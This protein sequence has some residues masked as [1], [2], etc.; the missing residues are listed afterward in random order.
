METNDLEKSIK[1][2]ESHEAKMLDLYQSP[3]RFVYIHEQR[4]A[5]WKKAKLKVEELKALLK[6]LSS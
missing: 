3:N 5:K 4:K 6:K 1:R 2:A